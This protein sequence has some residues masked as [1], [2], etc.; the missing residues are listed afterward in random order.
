MSLPKMIDTISDKVA[1]KTRSFVDTKIGKIFLSLTL[2]GPITFFPTV[3]IAWTAPNIDV[4]RTLTWP[5]MVVVNT[6]A[7]LGVIH[8]GDWRVRLT[9]VGWVILMFLT[10]LATLVR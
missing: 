10:F 7:L 8:N 2:I 9:L 4:L 6:S 1:K 5:L 3:Y